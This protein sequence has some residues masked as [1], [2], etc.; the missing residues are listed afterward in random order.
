MIPTF[1][2]AR[3]LRQTLESVFAQDPGPDVMQIEVIDDCSTQDDP[4]SVVRAAAGDRVHFFRQPENVGHARNFETCLQRSRGHLVHLLHGDDA[5]LHGFYRKMAQAFAEN[6]QLGAAFC[7]SV[8]M[9]GDGNWLYVVP[10]QQPQS[11]LLPDLVERLAVE[12]RFQTPAA[13]VRREVYETLGGFD[14]RLSW[15]EDWEMWARIAM[16]YP[17]WYEAEPLALY[18]IHDT[19]NSARYART[20]ENL[21]DL[22]RLFE[23]VERYVPNG[24]GKRLCREGRERYARGGLDN[25]RRLLSERDIAAAAGQVRASLALCLNLRLLVLSAFLLPWA[26]WRACVHATKAACVRLASF[27]RRTIRT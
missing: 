5:V 23:I 8:T 14:R 25:A 17:V 24:R 11:G 1:H 27:N 20:R 4:E 10:L 26:G 3:F 12:Q 18:R 15:T 22:K 16:H 9:D 2:C 19:S 6:L 21:R 13:V 7:R